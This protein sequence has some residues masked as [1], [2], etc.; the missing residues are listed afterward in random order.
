[1]FGGLTN[2]CQFKFINATVEQI[3]QG[4]G[5]GAFQGCRRGH[6]GTQG[7]ITGKGRVETTQFGTT[8]DHLAA[9]TENITSPAGAGCVFFIQPKLYIIL[10]V[11]GVSPDL[12]GTV[13][14]DFSYHT[15]V[16]GAREYK[17]SVVVGVFTNEVDA[18]R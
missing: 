11:D 18:T 14:T 8:F 10:E 17:T 13:E 5:I 1:V 3:V 2:E 9:Y 16:D 4:I 12:I 6:T 7:H 15:F